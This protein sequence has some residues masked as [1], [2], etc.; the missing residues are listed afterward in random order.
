MVPVHTINRRKT[1]ALIH[2]VLTNTTIWSNGSNPETGDRLTSIGTS[3]NV[4]FDET[5]NKVTSTLTIGQ[6]TSMGTSGRITSTRTSCRVILPYE[7][8][9][10]T[11]EHLAR[12]LG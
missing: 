8:I 7:A 10:V 6:V 1:N 12:F 11:S 4:A 9:E 2:T 3:D 5:S